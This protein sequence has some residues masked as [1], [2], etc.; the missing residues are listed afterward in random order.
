MVT[1]SK[2]EFDVKGSLHS[3]G[4]S[5]SKHNTVSKNYMK[6]AF[7]GVECAEPFSCSSFRSLSVPPYATHC[8][9]VLALL[10]VK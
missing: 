10:K 8:L 1:K 7:L 9:Q 6:T 4:S 3:E 5:F 2:V